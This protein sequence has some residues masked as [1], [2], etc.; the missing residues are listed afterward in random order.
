MLKI[1]AIGNSFSQDATSLLEAIA[2]S[3][4]EKWLVRNAYIG[5]CSLETHWAN[6]LSGAP[7]YEY[8]ENGESLRMV[9]LEEAL[10]DQE[11]DYVTL[12]QVSHLAGMP[13]TWT[14]FLNRMIGFAK[15][16]A[17]KAEIVLH[18]TWAY[19]FDSDHG[20]FANYGRDP[21]RMQ[22]A[23]RGTVNYFAQTRALRIIPTGD[24]LANARKYSEF[25]P[26]RGG[27]RLTRDGFHLSFD[28]GRYLAG[29]VWFSFFSHR[30]AYEVTFAPKG[31]D[32]RLVG[33]LKKSI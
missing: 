6:A 10:K 12:Q 27:L 16:L 15:Q 1:L 20:G 18:E 28:Y 22:E 8:Q 26:A 17:P 3:A 21:K 2:A 14:P 11:W 25:D 31:A 9:S 32:A 13:E 5:G 33:L 4:G 29:L 19:E 30:P 7:V 24:A 23:T